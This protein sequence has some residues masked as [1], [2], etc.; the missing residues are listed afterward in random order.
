MGLQR[1]SELPD[2]PTI[3]DRAESERV[4]QTWKLLL[5]RQ[6][7]GWPF[8]APPGLPP[9]RAQALRAAFDATMRD[10]AYRADAERLRIEIDP[11]SGEEVAA[12]I[13]QV[14]RTPPEIVSMLRTALELR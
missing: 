8:L 9:D 5:S 1:H 7:M 10:A 11:L 6:Q 3:M 14:L 2:L 13:D 4:R 12:L